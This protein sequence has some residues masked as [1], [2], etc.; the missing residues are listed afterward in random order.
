MMSWL[1][2]VHTALVGTTTATT[3]PWPLPALYGSVRLHALP[4]FS[5]EALYRYPWRSTVHSGTC[6]K[7]M[8][9]PVRV[10]V[11]PLLFCKDLQ[12]KYEH[13]EEAPGHARRLVAAAWQQ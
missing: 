10:R 5:L 7:I 3:T 11:P 4:K 9:S 1:R 2:L 8:V 12:G 6:L 13:S